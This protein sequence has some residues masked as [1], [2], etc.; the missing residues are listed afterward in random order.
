MPEPLSPARISAS[1]TLPTGPA[2]ALQPAPRE[3]CIR[4]QNVFTAFISRRTTIK[5]ISSPPIWEYGMNTYNPSV[6][7]KFITKSTQSCMTRETFYILYW[8][9]YILFLNDFIQQQNFVPLG[10]VSYTTNPRVFHINK[11]QRIF[12]SIKIKKWRKFQTQTNFKMAP[13]P[14]GIFFLHFFYQTI[15][16]SITIVKILKIN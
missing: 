6:K 2:A 4:L 9:F 11:S 14:S 1:S 5:S 7:N 13:P 3:K 8:F 16:V 10:E 12:M 15:S